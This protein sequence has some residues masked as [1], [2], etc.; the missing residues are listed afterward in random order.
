[1]QNIVNVGKGDFKMPDDGE[2]ERKV[3]KFL[4]R[5]YEPFVAFAKK[6]LFEKVN[7]V[8]I[9]G[10]LTSE[11]CVVVAD[12]YGHSSFMDKIQKAQMFNSN[13]DD[14][15]VSDFKKILEINPHHRVVQIV[16]DRINV[17]PAPRRP[18][19]PTPP[20]RN[21]SNSSTKPPPST[22]ASPPRTPTSSCAASTRSTPRPWASSAST[23]RKSTWATS[24]S[25]TRTSRATTRTSSAST[26]LTCES[27]PSLRSD[28]LEYVIRDSHIRYRAGV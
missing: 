28:C 11:P 21:S 24:N 18:T 13:A 15:P 19:P 2:R 7:N 17:P 1:M 22:R 25:P 10:R 12:T 20:L 5:R 14:N 6:V 26:P 3:Q 27:K 16:L 8:V 23:A 4:A 9:S